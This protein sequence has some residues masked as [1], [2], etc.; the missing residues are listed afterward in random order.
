MRKAARFT[1]SITLHR[2]WS[3]PGPVIVAIRLNN[4]C[5]SFPPAD[6]ISH[7]SRNRRIRRKFAPIRPDVAPGMTPFKKL[8]HTVLQGSEF[9]SEVECHQ[10][11]PTHRVTNI[12]RIL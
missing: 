4:E 8:Q 11:R 2:S 12:L 7:V 1:V 9:K 5:I 3:D 6:G 10:P